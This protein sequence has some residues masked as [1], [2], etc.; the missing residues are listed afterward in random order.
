[1]DFL[2]VD[3]ETPNSKNNSICSIGMTLVKRDAVVWS[4][5]QLINPESPFSAYNMRIHGITPA[6]VINAPNFNEF[7]QQHFSL[8]AHYPLVM[9]N[10][11]FDYSVIKQSAKAY[12]LSLPPL[13]IYDTLAL[14]S[15]NIPDLGDYTLEALSSHYGIE[16][17]HH[18]SASDSLVTAKLMLLLA[19]DERTLLHPTICD[20]G[21]TASLSHTSK[22]SS[23][24]RGKPVQSSRSV[25][26]DSLCI[27]SCAYSSEMPI[28]PGNCF[29]IT[30]CVIEDKK[31][32]ESMISSAGG[33]V[34]KNISRKVN[35]LIVGRQDRHIV[36]DPETGKTGK[37]LEA[38]ELISRGFPIRLIRMDDFLA[39]NCGGDCRNE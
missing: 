9:H 12:G 24:Q 26:T 1:M 28:I 37:I 32:A 33:K 27:P 4:K 39:L 13:C 38:E 2:A 30:C 29:C 36:T 6:D 3:V 23:S 19:S 21:L 5:N 15:I 11:N 31:N 35:Y 25:D 14:F 7:L 10:S 17:E 22:S 16:L 8:F 20:P 34:V 18:N